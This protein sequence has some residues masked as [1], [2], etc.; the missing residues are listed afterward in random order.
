[1]TWYTGDATYDTILL[2]AFAYAAL[3]ALG[4]PLGRPP[5]ASSR[6]RR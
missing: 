4:A 2:I 5:T 3:V 6:P 1:M